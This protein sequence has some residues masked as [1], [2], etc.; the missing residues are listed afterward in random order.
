MCHFMPACLPIHHLFPISGHKL[1]RTGAWLIWLITESPAPGDSA[2]GTMGPQQH[3]TEHSLGTRHHSV[4]V[5]YLILKIL[6]AGAIPGLVRPEAEFILGPLRK[7][8]MIRKIK[9]GPYM[10][11][12][13]AM[14]VRGAGPSSSK[15]L[16]SLDAIKLLH[17]LNM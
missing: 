10:C 9:Y 11:L 14:H 15:T 1:K 12:G 5:V 3:G 8:Y 13:M 17:L 16:Q 7:T 4:A 2:R 6:W